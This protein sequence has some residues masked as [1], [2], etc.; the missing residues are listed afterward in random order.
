MLRETAAFFLAYKN[1]PKRFRGK[2]THC[3][4][5]AY[6]IAD[7]KQKKTFASLFVCGADPAAGRRSRLRKRIQAAVCSPR[8][9]ENAVSGVPEPEESL[10]FGTIEVDGGFSFALAGTMYQQKDGSLL[11]YFTNPEDSGVLMMCEICE[12]STGEI[13]YQSGLLSPGQYVGRLRPQ[14]TLKNEAIIIEMKVYGFEPET[15]YS[16]GTVT[17]ENTLQPW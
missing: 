3:E 14:H 11:L 1:I 2:D 9:E 13:L 8:R 15:Y 4:S 6:Q 5:T 10:N 16:M 7:R 17:L 12:K